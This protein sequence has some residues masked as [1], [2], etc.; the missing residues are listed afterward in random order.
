MKMNGNTV[1]ITGGAGGIGFALAE[2]FLNAGNEV[3]ICSRKKEGLQKAQ[4]KYPA[5]H[6][7]ECDVSD[8]SSRD[9]LVSWIVENHLNLN[10]LVNNAGIQN[11][12]DFRL[13]KEEL[14]KGESEIRT[15]LEAPIYL[16]ASLI[17]LLIKQPSAAIVNVSSALGIVPMANMPV[18]CATKAGLHIF[19]KCLRR[20]LI[21]T[22]IRVFE[23][24]PPAVDTELNIQG[25]RGRLEA[26]WQMAMQ[27]ISASEYVSSVMERLEKDELEI[28]GSQLK[29]ATQ[30]EQESMF[31][32]MN[33]AWR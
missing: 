5:L 22:N 20:Q 31:E 19:T 27:T 7:R 29:N 10:I 12:I 30:A 18:Y 26:G 14:L 11:D 1:L 23:I 8:G 15:N 28:V 6:V 24:L 25:R 2:A 17:P 13:G 16:C 4:V 21:L 33:T 3:I 32:S 9:S